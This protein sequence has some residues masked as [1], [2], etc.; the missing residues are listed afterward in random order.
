MDSS[1]WYHRGYSLLFSLVC[2]YVIGLT[3]C[4]QEVL[5]NSW[6]VEISE[7]G[8]DAAREVAK[9][10]GFTYVSP[11]SLN[12]FVYLTHPVTQFQ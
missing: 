3:S 6:L 11:V 8:E 5:T 1:S 12:M 7:G 9:R 10:A 4:S 2:L